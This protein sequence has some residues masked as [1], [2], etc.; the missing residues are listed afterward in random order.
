MPKTG[1]F[2]AFS[3]G[4]D[5]GGQCNMTAT[6]TLFD[7]FHCLQAGEFQPRSK[8][9]ALLG[10]LRSTDGHILATA[11]QF[12]AVSAVKLPQMMLRLALVKCQFLKVLDDSS[13]ACAMATLS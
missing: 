4:L 13:R 6:I 7:T 11:R 8:N 1:H 12:G 2:T 9:G 10:A 5:E 3:E